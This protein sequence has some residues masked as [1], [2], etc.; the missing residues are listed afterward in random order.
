M[1]R[2]H[3]TETRASPIVND[4][5]ARYRKV[6][7]AFFAR[8]LKDPSQAEDFAQEVIVRL[9]A[10]GARNVANPDA[11]VF[12]IAGNL[13]R[14]HYRKQSVRD[15]HKAEQQG[16]EGRDVD[17]FDPERIARGRSE[18][19]TVLAALSEMPELTRRIFVLSRFENMTIQAVADQLAVSPSTVKNHLSRALIR[20]TAI[21][22]QKDA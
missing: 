11:Y 22:E 16:V 5:D 4:F 2:K 7:V 1:A 6:L 10:S 9:I 17:P 13:T 8:R 20:L 15:A 21:V 14:D 3:E 12:Q 18:L 19:N